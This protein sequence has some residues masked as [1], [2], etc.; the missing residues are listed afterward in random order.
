MSEMS[1]QGQEVYMRIDTKVFQETGEIKTIGEPMTADEV[2]REMRRYEFEQDLACIAEVIGALGGK[3]YEI[4][5][6]I[7]E[8]RGKDNTLITTVRELSEETK[9]SSQTVVNT[10][11]ILE[12]GGLIERK[13]GSIR[14]LVPD[15]D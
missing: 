4:F 1:S 10:L 8:H 13:V 2:D 11:K 7:I 15:A 5:K 6:Y 12:K 14:L 3:R 9:T